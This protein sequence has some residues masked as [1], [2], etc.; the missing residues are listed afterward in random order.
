MTQPLPSRSSL[1]G[2]NRQSQY[3]VM[4]ATWVLVPGAHGR[5]EHTSS[6]PPQGD[7]EEV[8]QEPSPEG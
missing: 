5:S 8:R 4:D 6:G 3:S 2:L 1:A 7:S